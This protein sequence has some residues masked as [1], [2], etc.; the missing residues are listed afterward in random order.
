MG[1]PIMKVN[2]FRAGIKKVPFS[3]KFENFTPAKTKNRHFS[4]FSTGFIPA[5][6]STKQRKKPLFENTTSPS[7]HKRKLN[8]K[9]RT[10]KSILSRFKKNVFQKKKIRR[11]KKKFIF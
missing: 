6:T 5:K 4:P 10:K 11:L 1:D 3:K 8:I 7:C 2:F 9:I